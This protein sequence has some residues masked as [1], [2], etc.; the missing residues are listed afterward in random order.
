MVAYD[1]TAFM[2]DG[3]VVPG[4]AT[5]LDPQQLAALFDGVPVDTA[6]FDALVS[7]K[8]GAAQ[9]GSMRMSVAMLCIA[10]RY[11]CF[12]ARMRTHSTRAVLTTTPAP[13]FIRST[14]IRYNV[15]ASTV[16]FGALP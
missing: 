7:D 8:H 14:G 2:S 1:V 4:P 6:Y 16:G 11:E 12:T 13:T 15:G 3:N 9:D 5:S 10:T